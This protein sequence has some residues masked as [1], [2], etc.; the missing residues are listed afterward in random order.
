MDNI[1]GA[2][3]LV[4]I[5]PTSQTYHILLLHLAEFFFNVWSGQLMT[6]M[7]GRGPNSGGEGML[8]VC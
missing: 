1:K 8:I 2:E 7:T 3:I 5:A 4:I 6:G